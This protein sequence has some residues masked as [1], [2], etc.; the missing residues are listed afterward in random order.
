MRAR[1]EEDRQDDGRD[2][3]VAV[4][5]ELS[6]RAIEEA[7]GLVEIA[8]AGSIAEAEE[9]AAQLRAADV[10]AI[11]KAGK[12]GTT[13]DGEP[14]FYFAVV[15]PLVEAD[16]AAE[17]LAAMQPREGDATDEEIERVLRGEGEDESESGEA[18]GGGPEEGAR[19]TTIAEDIHRA[20]PRF[21]LA[22][23]RVVRMA[24][25]PALAALALYLVYRLFA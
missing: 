13:G 22:V 5:D 3:P 1:S 10:A 23:L 12:W 19:R 20:I 17:V 25:W 21:A 15:V 2:R 16:R 11:A 6:T 14:W 7:T 18:G 4:P 24:A 9:I 8:H